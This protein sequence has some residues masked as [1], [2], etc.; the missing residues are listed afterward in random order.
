MSC[1]VGGMPWDG[2]HALVQ[3]AKG[4]DPEAW[5]DLHALAQEYLLRLAQQL[6]GPGW[7]H[8][9]ASDLVQD[10]WQQVYEAIDTF[11]GGEDDEQTG[12]MFR[13]LLSRTMRRLNANGLRHDQAAIR[14]PPA[15]TVHLGV[16]GGDDSTAGPGDPPAD[17]PTPSLPV[18]LEEQ[19]ATVQAALAKLDETDRAIVELRFFQGRTLEQVAEQ[20]GWT[21]DQVRYRLH[22]TILPRLGE[23]LKDWL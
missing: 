6:V 21:C 20:I 8:R 5:R 23:A 15:G 7:A 19:R 11:R 10:V 17:D 3:R 14:R 16:H 9:S 12:A 1:I 18:R 13:A 22:E 2:V 4:G